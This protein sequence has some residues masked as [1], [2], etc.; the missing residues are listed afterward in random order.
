MNKSMSFWLGI[1][2]TGLVGFGIVCWGIYLN[3]GY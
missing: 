2:L 1:A 3:G